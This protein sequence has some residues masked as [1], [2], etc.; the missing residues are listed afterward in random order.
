[1]KIVIDENVVRQIAE[2]LRQDGHEVQR[3]NEIARGS[4][5]PAVLSLANQDG[6]LLLTGDKDFGEL[7]FRQHQQTMGVV[8]IRLLRPSPSGEGR[9]SKSGLSG[10][11]GKPP[12]LFHSHHPA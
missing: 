6:A 9:N 5:D 10:K 2:R 11:R 4:K 12:P 1:M 8:L 7:V 3:I